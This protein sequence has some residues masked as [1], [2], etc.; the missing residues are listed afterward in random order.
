MMK[1]FFIQLVFSLLLVSCTNER[2]LAD[3]VLV[4]PYGAYEYSFGLQDTGE[5]R[6]FKMKKSGS[7]PY[8]YYFDSGHYVQR[9]VLAQRLSRLYIG[10]PDEEMG[11][12]YVDMEQN[13]FHPNGDTVISLK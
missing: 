7:D 2:D 4:K 8:V 9:A 3:L 1:L 10:D 11:L 5:L 13:L 12:P 6:Y